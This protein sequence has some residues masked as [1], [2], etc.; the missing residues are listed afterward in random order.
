MQRKIRGDYVEY[1]CENLPVSEWGVGHSRCIKRAAFG[2]CFTPLLPAPW[3][4][5]AAPAINV[6][7]V[8]YESHA[9]CPAP[10]A[11]CLC[12][13]CPESWNLPAFQK[14]SLCFDPHLKYPLFCILY[15]PVSYLFSKHLMEYGQSLPLIPKSYWAL[16]VSQT[17]PQNMKCVFM[18]WVLPPAEVLLL[19]SQFTA[20]E[21][22][23]TWPRACP[24]SHS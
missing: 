8:C 23:A 19:S 21:T 22:E 24:S 4:G 10:Q 14:N 15:C 18:Q 20:E 1:K 12:C 16:T 2:S 11:P 3:G 6:S 5:R 17:T 9:P 13:L 7:P